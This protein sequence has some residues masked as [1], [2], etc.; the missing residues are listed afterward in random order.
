MRVVAIVAAVIVGIV[1]ALMIVGGLIAHAQQHDQ[2][3][4]FLQWETCD[5]NHNPPT[6]CGPA[7]VP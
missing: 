7:P 1:V 3:Q 5:Y 6:V 2:L 4:R